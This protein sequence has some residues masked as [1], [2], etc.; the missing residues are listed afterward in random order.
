M[1]YQEWKEHPNFHLIHYGDDCGKVKVEE[2]GG[3]SARILNGVKSAAGK[4]PWMAYVTTS[5]G[6]YLINQFHTQKIS[7]K[8]FIQTL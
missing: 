5:F 6:V 7:F 8:F 2:E 3:I 4:L 1:C